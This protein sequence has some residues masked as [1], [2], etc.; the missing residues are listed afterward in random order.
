MDK[1]TYYQDRPC[2]IKDGDKIMYKIIERDGRFYINGEHRMSHKDESKLFKMIAEYT[3][4]G[5]KAED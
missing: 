4:W 2:T 3:M 5:K 1:I